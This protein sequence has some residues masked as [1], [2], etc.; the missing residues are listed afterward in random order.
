VV[1]LYHFPAIGYKRLTALDFSLYPLPK[2]VKRDLFKQ[3]DFSKLK[4]VHYLHGVLMGSSFESSIAKRNP[5][6]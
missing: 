1:P 5:M 3:F 6:R 2:E 4:N